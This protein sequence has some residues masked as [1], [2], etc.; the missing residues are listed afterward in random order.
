MGGKRIL[1]TKGQYSQP[2]FETLIS[3]LKEDELQFMSQRYNKELLYFRE[4]NDMNKPKS[5]KEYQEMQQRKKMITEEIRNRKQF[6]PSI[7]KEEIKFYADDGN[8]VDSNNNITETI[9]YNYNETEIISLPSGNH[10]KKEK[11]VWEPVK[12]EE[13]KMEY[14]MISEVELSWEDWCKK[15]CLVQ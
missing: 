4:Y 2:I 1:P 15:K 12:E 6:K 3:D 11:E 14:T 9:A 10:G 5:Q 13:P 8:I 7:P